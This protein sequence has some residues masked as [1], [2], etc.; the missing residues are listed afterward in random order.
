[1]MSLI[2]ASLILAA[3]LYSPG[4]YGK[5]M[6]DGLELAPSRGPSAALNNVCPGRVTLTGIDVSYY[7]DTINWNSVAA[8][9]VT[10]ALVR[11]SHG[12]QFRDSEFEANWANARAAGIHTG[13]YQYFEPGE[14]SIAQADLLLDA[15]GPLMRGDLPPVIDVESTGGLD[16]PQVAAA[17][18]T[19]VEHVEDALGVKPIIYTGPYFWQDNVGSDEFGEYPLWIAHYGT[20]CPL[21]P[22]PWLAWNFHQFTDS[23]SVNGV[24]GNVDTNSFN[25]TLDALLALGRDEAPTCGTIAAGGGTIDNGAD[26]LRL[27]GN[28]EFWRDE[29]VGAGGSLVWTNA[30]DFPDPGNY[31]TWQLWFDEAGE[32]Q[33]EVYIEG[34]IAES[35]QAAYVVDHAG[36]TDTVVVDQSSASGWVSLGTFGFETGARYDLRLDDNTGESVDAQRAI[37]VDALRVT[38]TG[39]GAESDDG[40]DGATDGPGAG[41]PD[42]GQGTDGAAGSD[43]ATDGGTFD[44]ALPPA[45]DKGDEGCSCRT[46]SDSSAWMLLLIVAGMRRRSQELLRRPRGCSGRGSRSRSRTHRAAQ[47]VASAVGDPGAAAKVRSGR[48]WC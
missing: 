31:A 29:P 4:Q 30:T 9:G 19:W 17:V 28:S 16:G 24:S 42:G 11:V 41:E 38:A 47:S 21:T 46:D 35:M 40:S 1:M 44:P 5:A 26:C 3:N 23:G 34:S 43:S 6:G 33:I 12:L 14:D 22:T 36:G 13:V 32:Y 20:D 7:Q 2:A 48:S 39:V 15:M 8:D 10:F 18:R 37:V 27:F 45:T 25:G